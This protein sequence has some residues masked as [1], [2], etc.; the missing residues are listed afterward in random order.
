MRLWQSVGQNKNFWIVGAPFIGLGMVSGALTLMF[1]GFPLLQI[2][3]YFN[4]SD[5]G[6]VNKRHNLSDDVSEMLLSNG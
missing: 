5:R 3:S 4:P 6:V 1:V 2:T